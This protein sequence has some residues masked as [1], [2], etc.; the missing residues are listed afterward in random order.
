MNP[1]PGNGRLNGAAGRKKAV[2]DALAV[3][4]LT[5]S[6]V[7]DVY[8]RLLTGDFPPDEQRPLHLIEKAVEE[9]KYTCYGGF[10][11]ERI[12]AY[13]FLGKT[14]KNGL[15][16]YL[17]V[18][19]SLRN[20]GWGSRFLQ[21][22]IDGPFREMDSVLLEVDD[23]DCAPDLPEREKRLRRLKFYLDNGLTDT[24]VRTTVYHVEYRILALPAG[25]VSAGRDALDTYLAI[26]RDI[27]HG[28]DVYVEKMRIEGSAAT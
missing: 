25:R 26:Y 27:P 10:I 18:E 15:V 2:T 5:R 28:Q 22:L 1:R 23:P 6:Q 8:N 20:R 19:K 7:R 14:G 24:G 4:V 16:D 17:A 3:R 11:G 13:A 9:G 21:A 12:A